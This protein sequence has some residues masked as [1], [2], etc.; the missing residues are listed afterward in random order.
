MTKRVS[1]E[2][3]GRC[4]R[5]SRRREGAGRASKIKC[6][7]RVRTG[8]ASDGRH[9]TSHKVSVSPEGETGG[10]ERSEIQD[11]MKE[12]RED[13]ERGAERLCAT[14]RK[15]RW[16]K[17][18]FGRIGANVVRMSATTAWDPRVSEG[19][20]GGAR[21]SHESDGPERGGR[22]AR[23]ARGTGR[24]GGDEVGARNHRLT[25]VA[26]LDLCRNMRVI[27]KYLPPPL[28]AC[29][30][31]LLSVAGFGMFGFGSIY[32]KAIAWACTLKDKAVK[33][34]REGS[35]RGIQSVDGS[36]EH[37]RRIERPKPYGGTSPPKVFSNKSLQGQYGLN[38]YVNA[39]NKRHVDIWVHSRRVGEP[40]IPILTMKPQGVGAFDNHPQSNSS[41]SN[42]LLTSYLVPYL[43]TC[44]S[45]LTVDLKRTNTYLGCAITQAA[46]NALFTVFTSVDIVWSRPSV[47]SAIVLGVCMPLAGFASLCLLAFNLWPLWIFRRHMPIG[48][49]WKVNA[50]DTLQG[51]I[52]PLTSLYPLSVFGR[53]RDV[54]IIEPCVVT[55]PVH[56]LRFILTPLFFRRISPAETP[57]YALSRNLFAVIAI[58]VVVF[59]AVT[60]LQKAQNQI[61]TRIKSATCHLERSRPIH[62]LVYSTGYLPLP[63]IIV[64]TLSIGAY[65]MEKPQ[66]FDI[67]V[68]GLSPVDY[69]G[70]LPVNRAPRIW[71]STEEEGSSGNL[72]FRYP[73]KFTIT[74]SA[75][76]STRPITPNTT[77][78]ARII[79]RLSPAFSYFREQQQAP[80]D[81]PEDDGNICD[82]IEDYRSG[83]VLDVVG[84]VGGFFALLQTTH[85]FLFGRPLLWGLTGAKLITPF[86]FLGALGSRG[87]KRRLKD[88]YQTKAADDDTETIRIA[89]F[90]RDFVIDFGP[91]TPE[92]RSSSLFKGSPRISRNWWSPTFATDYRDVSESMIPLIR[93]RQSASSTSQEHADTNQG[94]GTRI[95]ED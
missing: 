65:G 86:G 35:S 26:H 20:G 74:F 81:S 51:T 30:K 50:K 31:K 83:S 23:R 9:W 21:E 22:R 46:M 37:Q 7:L 11:E 16:S 70:E 75:E 28:V 33:L 6:I 39:G 59:R 64:K 15:N 69:R 54:P 19:R 56:A 3:R 73:L 4:G 62:M 41:D 71:L 95:D 25:V 78:S 14:D 91:A 10:K 88:Q 82:Y 40:V 85:V 47:P 44:L 92:A 58:A 61:G 27:G 48:K 55:L 66:T 52:S 84:S 34:N 42:K 13:K 72:T 45:S 80:Y 36:V 63:Q 32:R 89:S 94:E 5:V 60:A 18:E 79:T 68:R 53:P 8:V 57:I 1:A 24:R 87:F 76:L 12:V 90:L 43:L 93:S 17:S 29:A 77:A 49:L 67:E 2:R 38:T